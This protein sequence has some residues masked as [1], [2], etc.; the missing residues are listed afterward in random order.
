MFGFGGGKAGSAAP[1]SKI[2]ATT[3]LSGAPVV[4][5]AYIAAARHGRVPEAVCALVQCSCGNDFGSAKGPALCFKEGV[6]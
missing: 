4:E 3:Q 1:Q 6:E 5:E 2:E